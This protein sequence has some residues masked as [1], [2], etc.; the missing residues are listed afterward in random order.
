[1]PVGSGDLL[2]GV[3][4]AAGT[5]LDSYQKVVRRIIWNGGTSDDQKL[6]LKIWRIA[7]RKSATRELAEWCREIKLASIKNGCAIAA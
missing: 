7:K 4:S 6:A 1:M 2:G 3:M 5:S